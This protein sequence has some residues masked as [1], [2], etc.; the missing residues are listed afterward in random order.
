[1]R[2][3][4]CAAVLALPLGARA[5]EPRGVVVLVRGHD[6]GREV[7]LVEALRIYMRDRGRPV[8]LGGPA[9]AGP[10]PFDAAERARLDDEARRA[11]AEVVVWFGE[12]GGAPV[13]YALRIP[14]ADLRE[15]PVETDDPLLATRTLALKIRALLS[16][17][18]D[19]TSWS[20]PENAPGDPGTTPEPASSEPEPE[21]EPDSEPAPAPAPPPPAAPVPAPAVRAAPPPPPPRHAWLEATAAYGAMVPTSTTWVRHGLTV[22]LAAP[23][24]RLPLAAFAD[25]A[26]T[27]EPSTTVDGG[28]I[29]A[30]VWPVG[31]GLAARWRRAHWQLAGG[32][33]VSLQIVDAHAERGT[34]ANGLLRYS[35]G[36]GALGEV[37]WLFSR[38]VGAVAS[39]S[40]E[41]LVPRLELAAGTSGT[42]DLGWVQ[43]GLG[44]GLVVSL[45]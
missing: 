45:P 21:P 44:A 15:T 9:P 38:H 10:P 2:W 3:L 39:L 34:R 1:M 12:R 31:V 42:T 33:R 26:F 27:T 36:L 32:P 25:T 24:G 11:Q 43:F 6:H 23:L 35:A 41:A 8:Q 29:A 22:R 40:V 20:V 14:T 16:P 18:A 5:E 19:E 4:A 37:T 28:S 30:R 13:L 7:V 17:R